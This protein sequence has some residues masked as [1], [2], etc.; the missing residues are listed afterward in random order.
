MPGENFSRRVARAAA[1][2]G[3]RSY[4]AQTPVTWYLVLL[5]VCLL[6]VSLVT[7]SRYEREHPPPSV[8][9][10]QTPPT[11]TDEWQA[12]VAVDICGTFVPSA[13]PVDAIP[14]DPLAAIGNYVVRIEPG[15]SPDPAAF[16]GAKA[17]LGGFL[18]IEGAEITPIIL[19]VPGK[20]V[21]VPTTTTSSTTTTTTP[22]GKT[23]TS[24]S[25]TTTTSPTT[26]STTKAGK[27]TSTSSTSS[28]STS[29]T[30]TTIATRP[31]PPRVYKNGKDCG[32]KPGQ[33][34]V[35]TWSSPTAKTGHMVPAAQAS[36]LRFT[37]GQLITIAFLPKG[38][39]IPRPPA[40]A[41]Q[42][43]ATF[44]IEDPSGFASTTTTIPIAVSTTSSTTVAGSTSSTTSTTAKSTSTSS[45]SS[46]STTSSTG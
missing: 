35:E 2:G 23:T 10:K 38:V 3:G 44:L 41:R 29:T 18:S 5:L 12:A 40:V 11:S 7:Y 27:P 16:V 20:P 24:S 36:T 43:V 13:L 9:A 1:A 19:S 37:N 30:T 39:T 21:P 46:S 31:G 6:G 4:R 17:D 42:A 25:T 32:T 26:T 15:L 34:E 33:V 14:T 45:S 22:A 28:T 8:A